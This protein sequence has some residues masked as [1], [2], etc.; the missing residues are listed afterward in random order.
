L[1]VCVEVARKTA[2]AQV[3]LIVTGARPSL[4][5]PSLP[6]P[7]ASGPETQ[8]QIAR[9]FDREGVPL[10]ARALAA[11]PRGYFWVASDAGLH[12]FDG[13]HFLLVDNHPAAAVRI[14]ADEWVWAA[15]TAGL[16]AFRN[17]E[18]RQLLTEPVTSL[19]GS[20]T[21]IVAAGDGLWTGTIAGMKRLPARVNGGLIADRESNV[22]FGCET[23]FC[24]LTPTGEIKKYNPEPPG[25][26]TVTSKGDLRWPWVIRDDLQ[27]LWAWDSQLIIRIT[28]AGVV[29]KHHGPAATA[30]SVDDVRAG[31]RLP[32]GTIWI[33]GYAVIANG[34]VS[35]RPPPSGGHQDFPQFQL[36]ARGNLWE[37]SPGGGL[38]LLSQRSWITSWGTGVFPR[39]CSSI[40]RSADRLMAS[41]GHGVF[42]FGGY[43]GRGRDA[44]KR[45]PGTEMGSPAWASAGL[46]DG[47]LWTILAS[48]GIIRI[49]PDGTETGAAWRGIRAKALDFR[50]IFPDADGHF[51][52]GAKGGLFRLDEHSAVMRRQALDQAAYATAFAKGPDGKVWLGTDGGIFQLSNDRWDRIVSPDALRSPRIRSLA[53]GSGPVLWVGYREILPFSK[54]TPDASG[55]RGR[56][57]REDFSAAAGYQPPESDALLVDRRGWI[58]RS[59]QD[60]IYV[61]DG[62]HNAPED[63]IQL[64]EFNNLPGES[65]GAFAFFEDRD[66]SIWVAMDD[67]VAHID[68]DPAWFTRPAM[69]AA[70][71]TALRWRG[72]ELAWPSSGDTL[73]GLEGDLEI[74]FAQW[75]STI[76]KPA[77][78]QFRLLPLDQSWKR[79]TGG[80]AAY[81]DL[82]LGNYRFEIRDRDG[83]V[84]G[85]EFRVSSRDGFSW[86]WILAPLSLLAVGWT[87]WRLSRSTLFRRDYWKEKE[88]FLASRAEHSAA[89]MHCGEMV[90]ER[91]E[92]GERIGEG[93]FASVWKAR[94][95]ETGMTIAVK[96]LNAEGEIDAWQV[97]RFEKETDALRLLHDPGIV[98]LL[99]AGSTMEG[100]LWMAMAW[101]EGPSLREVLSHGPVAREKT[102]Q[103]VLQL[104]RA[105]GDAHARGVL[106]RDL[107]PE[108]ILVEYWKSERER[109]VVVDFGAAAVQ[110]PS[111]ARSALL[112]GSFD[113]MAPERVQ[114]RS[115]AATDVYGLGAVAFE[116][117]T[118]VRYAGVA[119]SSAEGMSRL[120]A[121][122][123][124][125]VAE[126]LARG[127][128][129]LP[130][131]R[132]SDIQAFS[133]DLADALTRH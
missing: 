31:L 52:V 66:G 25:P 127:L 14:T 92:I 21:H 17:G 58:W 112:L 11:D 40:T 106:H 131:K 110:H 27:N 105:L 2:W 102:A 73:T 128:A 133:I 64:H 1:G 104:G 70:H 28:P 32:D 44:W 118:G 43:S 69:P 54:L 72:H 71:V 56:W 120:L 76:P 68:P 5:A 49:A 100:Q 24:E 79:G 99:D 115:S 80:T 117:L 107:K 81:D 130:E 114:G 83:A 23:A 36:D 13:E 37:A 19:I 6:L 15:G 42:V 94:D 34:E 35:S 108:N 47:S 46:G 53:V 62:V 123:H 29:T 57:K 45:V 22:W 60:G 39:G 97:A 9:E 41:C 91:Y 113:Y 119:A 132:P 103:W 90:A 77:G 122:F 82:A 59:T 126:C 4:G 67:G 10:G 50:S 121:G 74:D 16:A 87:G 95:L 26:R 63:W 124:H 75:P 7:S 12:R 55:G 38:A 86:R 20:G 33:P 109:V 61:G 78:L 89:E 48:R 65:T 111:G 30:I 125:S 116:M 101:V 18:K 84:A 51:W 88:A 8:I 96:F 93:G 85:Y 3:L 98:R 129:Y